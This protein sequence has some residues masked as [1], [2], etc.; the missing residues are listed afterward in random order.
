[1]NIES[2][3]P[4][5]ELDD[6]VRCSK[7]KFKESFDVSGLVCATTTPMPPPPSFSMH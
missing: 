7:E 2:K 3:R 1:M 4:R 5:R 6:S